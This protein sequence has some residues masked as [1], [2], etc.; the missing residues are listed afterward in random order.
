VA[1]EVPATKANRLR[2]TLSPIPDPFEQMIF[3]W[4]IFETGDLCLT[5]YFSC[6]LILECRD[7]VLEECLRAT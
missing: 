6:D 5:R 1:V 4:T 2:E 7:L 3:L